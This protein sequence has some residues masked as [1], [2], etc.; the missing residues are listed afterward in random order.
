MPHLSPISP[1]ILGTV[2]S[3]M[4]AP[5]TARSSIATCRWP[6]PLGSL[7]K[8]SATLARSSGLVGAFGRASA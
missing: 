3:A 6:A 8:I 2:S 1:V 4:R 7:P 5:S